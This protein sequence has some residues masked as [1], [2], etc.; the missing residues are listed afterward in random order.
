[1]GGPV[2]FPLQGGDAAVLV[3]GTA[4]GSVLQLSMRRVHDLVAFC[5]PYE[6]EDVVAEVTG[7]DRVEITDYDAVENARR[8]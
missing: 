6:F 3:P 8:V 7:A 2:T 4:G 5:A 1:M